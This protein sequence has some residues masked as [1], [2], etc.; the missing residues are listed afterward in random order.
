MLSYSGNDSCQHRRFHNHIPPLAS[1][2]IFLSSGSSPSHRMGG[3]VAY[4]ML[5]KKATTDPQVRGS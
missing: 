4:F 3:L 2:V 5:T 1:S